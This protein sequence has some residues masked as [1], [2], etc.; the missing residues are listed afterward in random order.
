MQRNVLEVNEKYTKSLLEQREAEVAISGLLLMDGLDV[1]V[2]P[3]PGGHLE[4]TPRPA[5]RRRADAG[6]S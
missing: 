1:P 2:L 6:F 3:S 4:A 5:L